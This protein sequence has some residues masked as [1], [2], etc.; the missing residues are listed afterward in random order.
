MLLSEK[1]AKRIGVNASLDERLQHALVKGLGDYLEE[2]LAE[3]LKVYPKAVDIIE[4]PLMAGM[5]HIGDLFG[6][7]KMFLPQVVKAARTMKKAVSILQ[8]LIESEKSENATSAGRSC[9][10]R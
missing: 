10:L 8:P 5:N 1:E 2:D 4:G 9:W 3:A 6:A 7:G